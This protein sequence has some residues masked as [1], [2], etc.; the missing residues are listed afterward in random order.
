MYS[1]RKFLY[2]SAFHSSMAGNG[3]QDHDN[4]AT[5]QPC[6]SMQSPA[7]DTRPSVELIIDETHS[8]MSA[9]LVC[10]RL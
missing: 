2:R 3:D 5:I 6:G 1:N 10:N 9:C 4:K 7:S 8:G